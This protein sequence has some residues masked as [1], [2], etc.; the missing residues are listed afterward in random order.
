VNLLFAGLAR[1]LSAQ[2]G[3][4]IGNDFLSQAA[5]DP[6]TLRV[7]YIGSADSHVHE[8]YLAGNE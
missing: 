8:F 1:P 7:D 4:V 5:V 3:Q 2:N 6:S